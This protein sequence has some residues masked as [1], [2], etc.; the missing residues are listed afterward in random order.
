[1]KPQPQSGQAFRTAAA[2]FRLLPLHSEANSSA[3]A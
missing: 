1:V 2:R 3:R